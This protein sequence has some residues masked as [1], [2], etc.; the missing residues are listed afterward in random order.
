MAN[1][2]TLILKSDFS[3]CAEVL[4]KIDE[5]SKLFLKT[6]RKGA[7]CELVYSQVGELKRPIHNL[8]VWHDGSA[9]Q[10]SEIQFFIDNL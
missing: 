1:N 7:E 8:A 10:M 6:H 5:L 3:T 4:E 9:S 2:Q